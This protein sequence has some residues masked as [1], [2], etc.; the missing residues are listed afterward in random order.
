MQSV[1]IWL[2]CDKADEFLWI[3][4]SLLLENALQKMLSPFRITLFEWMVLNIC[5]R[6]AFLNEQNVPMMLMDPV[7]DCVEVI[8]TW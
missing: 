7:Y 3:F 6:D 5:F 2:I 4:F 1:K 8:S